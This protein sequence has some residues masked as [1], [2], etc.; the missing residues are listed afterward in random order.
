MPASLFG[1]PIHQNTAIPTAVHSHQGESTAVADFLL[2]KEESKYSVTGDEIP[3]ITPALSLTTHF[4]MH[5]LD[6]AT[7]K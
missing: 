1:S 4:L 6:P 5:Q 2:K 3:I 7:H